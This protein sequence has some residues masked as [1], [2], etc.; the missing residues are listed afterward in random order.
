M[1]VVFKAV[2]LRAA[3][4]QGQHR[5]EPVQRL[6]GGLFVHA[7]H[8]RVLR[9]MQI[10]REDVGGLVLEVRIGG[11]HIAVHP[12]RPQAV[13]APHPGD[14]HVRDPEPFGEFASAPMGRAGRLALDRPFQN[15]R[16]QPRGERGGRLAGVTAEQSGQ[17]LLPKALAPAVDKGVVAGELLAGPGPGL[18][19]LEQQNQ[20]R[21]ARIVRTPCLTRRSPIQFHA[22]RLREFHCAHKHNLTIFSDVTVH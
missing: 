1:A 4:G 16:L 17:A 9:R 20:A 7:K 19:G 13:L 10:Q 12:L 21:S 22:L 2:P 15:A 11:S 8:R 18:S 3:R 14:H 5:V 6:D